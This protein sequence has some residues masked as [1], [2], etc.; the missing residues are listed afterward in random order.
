MFGPNDARLVAEHSFYFVAWRAPYR[1][2]TIIDSNGL[3][4]MMPAG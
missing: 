1:V 4:F 3:S 2:P